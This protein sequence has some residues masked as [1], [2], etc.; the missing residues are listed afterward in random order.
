MVVNHPDITMVKSRIFQGSLKYAPL[1][2]MNPNPIIF[3]TISTVYK[4]WKIYSKV[5]SS[6]VTSSTVGSS[7]AKVIQLR[8]M[9]MID[10]VSKAGCLMIYS[11]AIVM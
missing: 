1:P 6:F 8:R 3:N 10:A 5:V 4:P 2:N 11:A 9:T 7:M